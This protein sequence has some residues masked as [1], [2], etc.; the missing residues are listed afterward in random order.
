MVRNYIKGENAIILAVSPANADLA[1]SD[2][3]RMARDVDPNGERTIGVLT[4]VDIMDPGTSVRDILQSKQ[5]RL[6]NGWVGVVNRGQKDINSKMNMQ[7][8]RQRE[9]DFFKNDPNYADLPNVGTGYLSE[10]LSARLL[11]EI[12]RALPGIQSSIK[13]E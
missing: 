3:L 8:A 12:K 2:A 1:T 6:K 5:L 11:Y 9:S 4:K 13:Q 7:L 10:K